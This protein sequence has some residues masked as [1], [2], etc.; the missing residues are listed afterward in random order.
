MKTTRTTDLLNELSTDDSNIHFK[1]YITSHADDMSCDNLQ[2]Y[3]N[4]YFKDHPELLTADVIKRSNLDRGYA[5][6]ILNGRKPHPG[7]YKLVLLALCA[8]MNLKEIQRALTISGNAVLYPKFS[9]DAAL[10]VCINQNCT[11][12]F[13]VMNF[14]AENNLDF[15]E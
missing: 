2:D 3:F 4:L 5:Y 12:A 14:F 9:Q 8:G 10:G 15:P 6:Q 13:E 1:S 7:K 11:S